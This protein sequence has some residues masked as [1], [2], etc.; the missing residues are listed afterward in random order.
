[1]KKEQF[2]VIMNSL[3]ARKDLCKKYLNDIHTTEDISKL[4][5]AKAAELKTFCVEEEIVMTN[6][7]MVDLYH[8][9]GMGNLTPI[10]MMQFTYSIRDYLEYRP[11]V[12]A[13]VKQLN[14]IMNLPKIPV[15]TQYK[16]KGLGNMTLTKGEGTE[17]LDDIEISSLP[18][19]LNKREITVDATQLDYFI[20]LLE[21]INKT[22]LSHDTF[23][24]KCLELKEYAGIQWSKVTDTEVIGT[25]KAADIYNRVH[26][27]YN[28]R[29][30]ELA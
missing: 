3:E 23:K 12:K 1:M 11:I 30:L 27:F 6:I 5:I 17:V 7:A 14:S 20:E 8:I 19:S 24:K 22:T 4:T 9:I 25:I 26:S 13:M 18:F 21:K 28:K 15:K 10:Q 16:L 29:V 2:D